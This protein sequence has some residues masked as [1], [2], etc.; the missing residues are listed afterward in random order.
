[1]RA[2]TRMLPPAGAAARAVAA[3]HDVVLHS[4]DDRA[5]LAGVKAAVA[6]GTIGSEQLDRSVRRVLEAKARLGLHR[7]ARVDLDALAEIVGTRA[8]RAVAREVSE[9]SI[10]LI[11][12]AAG[13]VPLRTPRD[14]SLLYLSNPRLSLR[15][16]HRR[17]QPFRDS[18]AP[19]ALARR[20]RH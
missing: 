11:R 20:H 14:G 4:P 9:R 6:D 17:A 8:H 19:G 2:V 10:T 15:L 7:G 12:D 3:G 1:M 5:A 18:R 16:G 13:D